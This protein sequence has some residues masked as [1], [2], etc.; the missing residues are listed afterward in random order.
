MKNL[1]YILF[2]YV[3]IFTGCKEEDPYDYEIGYENGYPNAM[4]GVW[5]TYDFEPGFYEYPLSYT[6]YEM[7]IAVDPANTDNLIIDNVYNSNLRVRT[8]V[9]KATSEYYV[10]KGEQLEEMNA[11][12]DIETISI[13]GVYYNEDEAIIMYIGLYDQYNDLF[14]TI[15]V[16]GFRK[17]G[18]EDIEEYEYESLFE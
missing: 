6:A 16:I 12:Y 11:Q 1:R 2:L 14:D 18:F 7:I 5:K 10:I 8:F 9:N 17:T 13:M 4:A 3:L 15:H